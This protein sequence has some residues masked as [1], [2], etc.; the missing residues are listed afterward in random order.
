MIQNC[1]SSCLLSLLISIIPTGF[2]SGTGS[3]SHSPNQ[4][5]HV[6][7]EVLIPAGQHLNLQV[8]VQA[9]RGLSS[10]PLGS[11]NPN[12]FSLFTKSQMWKL[13]P[14]VTVHATSLFAFLV[15]QHL[16]NSLYK[17]ILQTI[18]HSIAGVIY[19]F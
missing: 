14:A 13:L 12:F 4:L 1:C 9:L 2:L 17:I 11:H 19:V 10:N 6:L 18:L 15:F 5:Q 3:S 7:S 8:S 16:F